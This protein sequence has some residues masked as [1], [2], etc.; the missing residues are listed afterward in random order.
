MTSRPHDFLPALGRA[1][2]TLRA[3][4]SEVTPDRRLGRTQ[5]GFRELLR[6]ESSP[7]FKESERPVLEEARLQA[8]RFLMNG[9]ADESF[10]EP[11]V[12][13][14]YFLFLSVEAAE[15]RELLEVREPAVSD[16]WERFA[17]RLPEMMDE[18]LGLTKN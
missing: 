11:A 12:W 2:D 14:K 17:E 15:T 4:R 6:Y 18:T 3:A 1:L 13:T 7:D 8:V 16:T 9:I 5:L 10:G